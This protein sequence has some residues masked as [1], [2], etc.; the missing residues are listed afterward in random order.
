[1]STFA[2][3]VLLGIVALLA[4]GVLWRMANDDRGDDDFGGGLYA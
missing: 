2:G 3:W 4:F 1:M